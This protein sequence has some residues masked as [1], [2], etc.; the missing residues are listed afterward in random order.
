MNQKTPEQRAAFTHLG[1]DGMPR[2]VDVSSKQTTHRTATARGTI[3]LP[4]ALVLQ[5][6]QG[7]IHTKKGAVLHTAVVAGTL[8]V[9][10][11]ADL[12]PFCHPL[13]I[14]GIQFSHRF[15]NDRVL[16]MHCEVTL[17]HKTGVEMEALTGV[18]VALL[19]VYDMCKSLGQDMQIS[20]LEVIQKTGGKSDIGSGSL[21]TKP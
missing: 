1:A 17:T 5:Q 21:S 13:P 3:R 11:T 4:S 9:K 6:D 20:Q 2:M 14:E 7:E 16:E 8:A 12:I 15:L 19:T 10:R 18:S